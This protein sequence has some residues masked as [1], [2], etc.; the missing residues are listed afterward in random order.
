VLV[1]DPKADQCR[2]IFA[3]GSLMWRPGFEFEQKL[4]ANLAGYHRRLSVYSYHY[5]GT[6]KHPGLVFGLD[7]GG[8]CE[9]LAYKVS[10]I[11]WQATLQYV[12]DRELITEIYHEVVMPISV[13]GITYEAVTYVVDPLHEQYA[14]AKSIAE[15]LAMVRQGQGISG[16]C[17]D[18]ITN[19]VMHL[20][21]IGVHDAELEA[22]ARELI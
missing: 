21:T 16:S 1:L 3:Y 4:P 18:Y 11:N 20:R 2:W 8:H 17:V 13:A 22:L 15:T 7:H 12:R 5:R 9:G 14:E 6:Q 19:T 10:D